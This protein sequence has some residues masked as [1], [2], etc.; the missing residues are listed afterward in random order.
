M[1]CNFNDVIYLDV[2]NF[3]GILRM[4][5]IILYFIKINYIYQ[6]IFLYLEI[7]Y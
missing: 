4:E 3:F 2:C 5:N 1:Y 6:D 7:Y